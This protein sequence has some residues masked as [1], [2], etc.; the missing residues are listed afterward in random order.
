MTKQ[1]LIALSEE[2]SR[3]SDL[4]ARTAACIAV[5]GVAARFNPRFDR[6][7]F[8]TACRVQ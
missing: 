8:F 1:H 7:R 6:D 5:A 3:I 4:T 2:I